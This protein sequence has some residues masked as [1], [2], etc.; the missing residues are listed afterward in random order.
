MLQRTG[1]LS[2]TTLCYRAPISESSALLHCALQKAAAMQGANLCK[3][4][5]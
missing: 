5:E 3:R 1:D 2:V 4:W